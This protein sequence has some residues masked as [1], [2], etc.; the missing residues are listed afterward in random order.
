MP[1][2]RYDDLELHVVATPYEYYVDFDVYRLTL[3]DDGEG[4]PLKF[5]TGSMPTL[6]ITKAEKLFTCTTKWDGC[7]NIN[8]GY[9][10]SCTREELTSFGELFNR[11]FDL[12]LSL[13]PNA[14]CF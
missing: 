12:T 9:I 2:Y 7:S 10:H 6:D 8:F 4:T 5:R 1:N 11:L 13:C 14:D 3:Q